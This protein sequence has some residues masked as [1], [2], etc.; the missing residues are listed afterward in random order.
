MLKSESLSIDAE[1]PSRG[2]IV[3]VISPSI[4]SFILPGV[5]KHFSTTRTRLFCVLNALACKSAAAVVS[6]SSSGTSIVSNNC[7]CFVSAN[8]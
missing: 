4:I 5:F 8:T 7:F 1:A 6:S 2:S 3:D